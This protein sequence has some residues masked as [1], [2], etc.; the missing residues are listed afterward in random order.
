[1]DVVMVFVTIINIKQIN[2]LLLGEGG[3]PY[4]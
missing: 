3:N 1:M 2:M 4:H